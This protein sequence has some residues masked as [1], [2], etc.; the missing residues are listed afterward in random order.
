MLSNVASKVNVL[1]DLESGPVVLSPLLQL[2]DT[3]EDILND[4]LDILN[5]ER[6]E[7]NGLAYGPVIVSTAPKVR[8]SP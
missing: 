6:T 7:E 4:S 5:F 3:M 1:C 2:E 8:H